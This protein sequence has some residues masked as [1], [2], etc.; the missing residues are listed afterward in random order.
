MVADRLNLLTHSL[1]SQPKSVF[2]LYFEYNQWLVVVV[3]SVSVD[4]SCSAGDHILFTFV[5]KF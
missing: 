2:N 3:A 4:T 1:I 5:S